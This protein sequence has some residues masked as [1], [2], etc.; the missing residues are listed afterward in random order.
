LKLAFYRRAMTKWNILSKKQLFLLDKTFWWWTL[1]DERVIIS[2][3]TWRNETFRPLNNYFDDWRQLYDDFLTF[4]CHHRCR[5][6][7]KKIFS[8]LLWNRNRLWIDKDKSQSLWFLF[9]P[10][11][12]KSCLDNSQRNGTFRGK[13]KDFIQLSN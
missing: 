4:V 1:S 13:M 9:S 12:L 11:V 6:W 3:R 7:S 2:Y 5:S 10:I 8:W